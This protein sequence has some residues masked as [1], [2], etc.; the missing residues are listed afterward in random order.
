M[1][2]EIR[3][4]FRSLRRRHRREDLALAITR[5]R[6]R[7]LPGH[8]GYGLLFALRLNSEPENWREV[9]GKGLWWGRFYLW[10][11]TRLK[12]L[13]EGQRPFGNRYRVGCWEEFISTLWAQMM[14]VWR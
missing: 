4:C 5:L 9:W 8:T 2:R 11:M 12:R 13:K 10:N 6:I 7:G 14:E 3:S 1:I